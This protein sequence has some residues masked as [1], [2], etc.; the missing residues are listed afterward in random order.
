M[1]PIAII[2][3]P[4]FKNLH[5]RDPVTRQKAIVELKKFA[6]SSIQEP[7]ST[8]VLTKNSNLIILIYGNTT[9][10]WYIGNIKENKREQIRQ[11]LLM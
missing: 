6:K 10:H 3:Y 9:K 5:F 8:E 11:Q 1:F 7:S 2:L 4:R